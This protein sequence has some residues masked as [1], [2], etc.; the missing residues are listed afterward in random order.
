M[1][2]GLHQGDA[3][4]H[5][6]AGTPSSARE[7]PLAIGPLQDAPIA[8]PAITEPVQLTLV[9]A[10]DAGGHRLLDQGLA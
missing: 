10:L 9:S 3:L 8:L 1:L 5:H 4:W 7:H 2:D 6:Q